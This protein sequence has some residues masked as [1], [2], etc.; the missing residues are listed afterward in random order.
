MS[1]VIGPRGRA[2]I[3]HFEGCRLTA[4]KDA[5]GVWTIGWGSTGPAIHAGLTWTQAQA[6]ADLDRR[7]DTEFAPGVVQALAGAPAT[8]A[9]FSALV[10]LAYNIGLSALRSSTLLRRHRAG[11][12]AGAAEEFARWRFAGGRVL[13]GLVRRRAAERLLYLDRLDAFDAMIGHQS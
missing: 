10:S 12:I 3:R 13:A 2:C 6:D 5:V 11:D 8:A 1:R 4:Y 7:L 9:Q